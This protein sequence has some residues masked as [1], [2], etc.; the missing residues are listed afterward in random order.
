MPGLDLGTLLIDLLATT[1]G[2]THEQV[3]GR[4]SFMT[5]G[6][7]FAFARLSQLSLKLP[8]ETIATLVAEDRAIPLT[9]GK[10]TMKEWAVITRATL[11]EYAHELPLI[12]TARHFVDSEAAKP[13]PSPAKRKPTTPQSSRKPR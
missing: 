9:L 4:F 13:K 7:V 10:R 12:L 6:K 8:A 2:V 11:V 3:S 5:S 1:P